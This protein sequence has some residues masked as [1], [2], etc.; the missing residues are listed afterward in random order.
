MISYNKRRFKAV[1][2]TPECSLSPETIF[3]YTQEDNIVSATYKGGAIISGSLLGVVNE[4]GIL[5]F[6]YQHVKKD[7]K[8]MTGR[9]SATTLVLSDG[10]LKICEDWESGDGNYRVGVVIKEE[11]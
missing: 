5:D 7:E 10:R 8:I 2:N 6:Y 4:E 9:C 11:I 1:I 3:E